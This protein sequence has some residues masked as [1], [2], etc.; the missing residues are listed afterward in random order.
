MSRDLSTEWSTV[1][2]V[3]D[4]RTFEESSSSTP[5]SPQPPLSHMV[6]QL[7]PGQQYVFRVTCS[8]SIGVR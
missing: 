5:L 1:A 3:A 2:T 4:P 7:S 8:N 6:T